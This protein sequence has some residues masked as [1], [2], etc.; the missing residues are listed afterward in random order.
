MAQLRP[1]DIWIENP[2]SGP[3]DY[4][5]HDVVERIILLKAA[6]ITVA[7]YIPLTYGA[8]Q[9]GGVLGDLAKWHAYY[10]VVHPFFDE[11]PSTWTNRHL[12]HLWAAARG[13]QSGQR[14]LV[15]FNPGEPMPNIVTRV[16]EGVVICTW[17]NAEGVALPEKPRPWEAAIVHSVRPDTTDETVRIGLSQYQYAYATHDT[18]PNPF[19]GVGIELH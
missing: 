8:R 14:K 11:V 10:G 3:G 16:A 17:E 6:G 7:G 13:Y 19:D 18:L 4:V 9:I 12:G 15:I 2:N 1:G 5:D